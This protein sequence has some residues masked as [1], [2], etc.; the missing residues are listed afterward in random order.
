MSSVYLRGS[1]GS[2]FSHHDLPLYDDFPYLITRLVPALYHIIPL[3]AAAD[4]ARLLNLAR[5]QARCNQLPT[6]LVLDTTRAI[7]IDTTGQELGPTLPPRGGVILCD[8]LRPSPEVEQA[9][10]WPERSRRLR[11]VVAQ[12]T[13]VREGRYV[14]GDLTKGGR[15]AT[16]EE[17]RALW[18]TTA[19]GI[20]HGLTPCPT[21]GEWRGHCLDQKNQKN[22]YNLVSV[23]CR[24]ENGNRCAACHGLLATR[25]LNANYFDTADGRIWHVPGFLAYKHRC[26]GRTGPSVRA[27]DGGPDR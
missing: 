16:L 12:Q 7:F 17:R 5:H 13:A 20:P 14:L 24:C 2:Q 10:E 22:P 3:P 6:C 8:G 25:K 21:C 23:S 15:L 9:T 26:P 18:G 1:T 4:H 11:N 27:F 19:A